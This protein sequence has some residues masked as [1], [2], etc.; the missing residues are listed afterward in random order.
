MNTWDV[1]RYSLQHKTW[2]RKLCLRYLWIKK[3]KKR[4]VGV[5]FSTNEVNSMTFLHETGNIYTFSVLKIQRLS[6]EGC[7]ACVTNKQEAV[8]FII[9][10]FSMFLTKRVAWGITVQSLWA[11]DNSSSNIS[12]VIWTWNM[13]VMSYFWGERHSIRS[14]SANFLSCPVSIL[15]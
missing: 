9:K 6:F 12:T 2:L 1:S 5:L 14:F 8:C 15:R 13:Q 7:H 10:V 4:I 11:K 3:K